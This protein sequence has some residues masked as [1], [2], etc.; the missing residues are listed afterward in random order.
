M[1]KAHVN[2]DRVS[3]VSRELQRH[4]TA[5]LREHF[6]DPDNEQGPTRAND[7]LGRPIMS[8]SI[9]FSVSRGGEVGAALAEPRRDPRTTLLLEAPIV[10][11]L[12]RMA[13]PNILAG[14]GL[15]RP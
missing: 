15:D 5:D 8:G 2:G 6:G 13:A 10:Q 11:T 3:F 7:V 4:L 12:L 9:S 14:A 1:T